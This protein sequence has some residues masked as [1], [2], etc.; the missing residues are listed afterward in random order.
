MSKFIEVVCRAIDQLVALL[1]AAMVILVFGNVVL[2]YGFNSGI[3]MTEELSRWLFVWLVFLGAIVAVR[4]R[5]H[6][7]TDMVTSRLPPGGKKACLITG[8][9]LML[10][11]TW[12]FFSGSLDQMLIN[13]NVESPSMGLPLAVFY[14]PGLIYSVFASLLLVSD[15]VVILLG[16]VSESDLSM[17]KESEDSVD[18]EAVGIKYRS[19][20]ANDGSPASASS[21]QRSA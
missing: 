13:S 16:R 6:L 9:L 12:L 10:Y 4:E 15:L 5:A 11:L 2:R 18:T 7:G 19:E 20:N 17:V 14:A 8:H 3:S 21:A 1:L